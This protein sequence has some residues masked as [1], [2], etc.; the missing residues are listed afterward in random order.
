[1]FQYL[2]FISCY[3]VGGGDPVGVAPDNGRGGGV[4]VWQVFKR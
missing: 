2:P 3:M 1:M 4:K